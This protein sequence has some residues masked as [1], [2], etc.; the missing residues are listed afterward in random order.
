V[1]EN[2]LLSGTTHQSPANVSEDLKPYVLHKQ[3]THQ[4][5]S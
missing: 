3:P 1:L 5:G 4:I 2:V